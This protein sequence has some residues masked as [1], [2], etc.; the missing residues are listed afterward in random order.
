MTKEQ[1]IDTI[2]KKA[3]ERK[4]IIG[5]DNITE[6]AHKLTERDCERMEI[7]MDNVKDDDTTY[8]TEAQNIFDEYYDLITYTLNI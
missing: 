3:E 1:F 8:T 4:N 5:M 6:L 7:I 2:Q